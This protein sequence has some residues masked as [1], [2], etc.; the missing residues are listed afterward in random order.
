MTEHIYFII[1]IHP[2]CTKQLLLFSKTCLIT[3]SQT[4]NKIIKCLYEI[5]QMFHQEKKP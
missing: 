3:V 5:K 2:H 1:T 4:D